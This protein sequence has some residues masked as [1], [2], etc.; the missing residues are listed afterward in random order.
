M[1]VPARGRRPGSSTT[2]TDILAAARELFGEH[3]Y[4]RTSMRAVGR[5]AQVDPALIV[6][7][8]G[9]KD[10]LLREALTLPLDPAAVLSEALA[11]VPADRVG[12]ELVRRVIQVWDT[13]EMT[14]LLL[15]LLRTAVSHDLA[16]T[17]LRDMLQRTVIAAVSSLV[18]EDDA[19]RRAELVAAQMWGLAVTRYLLRLPALVA[20]TPDDLARAVGPSVQQYLTGE[21]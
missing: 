13:P 6:H 4:E 20:M 1:T 8:F 2:R 7:Y 11:G 9:S 14:P 19:Q 10:G 5:R 18:G 12:Q 17:Y 3:G 16:M 21:S 15:S